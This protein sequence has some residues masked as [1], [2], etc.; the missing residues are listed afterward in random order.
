M[1]QINIRNLS[2]ENDDGSLEIVGVST[3][4]ATSF[5]VP[6]KGTT[7]ERPSECEPGSIRFNTDTANLEYFRGKTLGW[8]QFELVTP[9]LGQS[10]G[11]GGSTSVGNGLG[12]RGVFGMRAEPSIT[13]SIDFITISTMGN[14]QD[15][16]NSTDSRYTYSTCASRTRG[17]MAG[18]FSALVDTIDFVTFASTG[19][20][21]DF[22]N[23]TQSRWVMCQGA[24]DS[25][26]GMFVGGLDPGPS[27]TFNII[28]FITMAQTGNAVDFG[29]ISSTRRMGSGCQSSTRAIF[30]GGYTPSN[31]NVIDFVTTSTT[32]D[33][34]DFG[35]LNYEQK[36]GSAASNSTRGLFFGGNDGGNPYNNNISFI[37]I[38]T[39]GNAA[40][41][42]DLTVSAGGGGSSSS[43]TRAVRG[44]GLAPGNS[45]VID[46]VEILTLGNAVDFGNLNAAGHNLQ[47]FSNGHGG[48]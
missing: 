22:G 19:N 15:F 40:D 2:N 17:F 21:T 24:A 34:A 42:G 8:S 9:N 29:D 10:G 25:T 1:S 28:D 13:D 31:T 44:G 7:A 47:G 30:A 12:T 46:K 48:L 11:D 36:N 6:P 18:G 39:K 3:F 45:D 26:R 32:G 20:A 5:F 23:L 33:A 27:T 35:D 4:S 41:F 37:T 14:A 43:S 16:G 38:A